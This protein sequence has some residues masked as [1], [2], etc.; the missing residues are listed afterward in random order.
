[1]SSSPWTLRSSRSARRGSAHT[2][3]PC[4]ATCP[5]CSRQNFQVIDTVNKLENELSELKEEVTLAVIGC[6]VNG[7]G[8]SKVADVGVTGATPKHLIYLNGKPAY[9]V[10][11]KDL[12]KALIKEVVEIAEKKRNTIVKQ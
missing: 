6:Y 7:P 10:E 8:E 1:M 5:S 2:W 4:S 9:K 11:T 12:E 3:A